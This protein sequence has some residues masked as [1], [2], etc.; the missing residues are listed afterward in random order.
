[1]TTKNMSPASPRGAGLAAEKAPLELPHVREL[2]LRTR[3]DPELRMYT[4]Y[5]EEYWKGLSTREKVRILLSALV[6][7][8]GE[9]TPLIKTKNGKIGWG[10][11]TDSE[12]LAIAKAITSIIGV[13]I[14]GGVKLVAVEPSFWHPYISIINFANPYQEAWKV[15][16]EPIEGRLEV[17]RLFM[18]RERP[19]PDY[20]YVDVDYYRTR[21]YEPILREVCNKTNNYPEVCLGTISV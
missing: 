19:I 17:G 20:L 2:L 5:Q 12:T 4:W 11:Y 18:T 16:I 7:R 15:F 21:I 9:T 14:F 10:E 13:R 8:L 1:M 3:R 6:L